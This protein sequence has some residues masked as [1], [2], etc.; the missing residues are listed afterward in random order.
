[1]NYIMDKVHILYLDDPSRREEIQFQGNTYEYPIEDYV[2]GTVIH[3]KLRDDDSVL[4]I[5]RKIS[6]AKNIAVERMYMYGVQKVQL[7]NEIVYQELNEMYKRPTFYHLREYLSNYREFENEDDHDDEYDYDDDNDETISFED[8]ITLNFKGTYH[9]YIAIGISPSL[10]VVNPFLIERLHS[11]LPNET[12]VENRQLLLDYNIEEL[13]VVI[14]EGEPSYSLERYYPNIHKESVVDKESFIKRQSVISYIENASENIETKSEGIQFI[15]FRLDQYIELPL[16]YIFNMFESSKSTPMIKYNPSNRLNNQYRIYSHS[17]SSNGDKIPYLNMKE[18]KRADE[19][20]ARSKGVGIFIFEKYDGPRIYCSFNPTNIEFAVFS[21]K[22]ITLKDVQHFIEKNLTP[23]LN[24]VFNYISDSGYPVNPLDYTKLVVVKSNLELRVPFRK[25]F[26]MN[27]V[28]KC[29]RQFMIVNQDDLV[30]KGIEMRYSRISNFKETDAITS[31]IIRIFNEYPLSQEM[32]LE[33]YAEILRENFDDM[34]LE[35]ALLKINEYIQ[36][37]AITD[38]KQRQVNPGYPVSMEKMKGRREIVVNVEGIDNYKYFEPMIKYFKGLIYLAQHSD[39]RDIQQICS[40]IEEEKVEEEDVSQDISEEKVEDKLKEDGVSELSDL[41]DDVSQDDSNDDSSSSFFGGNRQERTEEELNGMSLK[42]PNLFVQRIDEMEPGLILKRRTG[43]YNAYT[44]TCP[45]NVFRQPVILTDEEMKDISDNY[46]DAYSNAMEY[47]TN[48][49]EK[50]WYICPRYWCLKTGKPLTQEQV[51]SGQ[52][53]KVIPR[54]T[55]NVPK[56]HYVYEFYNPSEHGSRDSYRIHHPGLI[57]GKHP[58]GKCLPC[59]FKKWNYDKIQKQKEK[60]VGDKKESSSSPKE[61]KKI[62]LLYIKDPEKVPLD[63]SRIGYMSLPL[64]KMMRVDNQK[65]K[66]EKT[67]S[68]FVRIGNEQKKHNNFLSAFASLLTSSGKLSIDYQPQSRTFNL[69]SLVKKIIKHMTLDKFVKYMRGSL[70]GVFADDTLLDDEEIDELKSQTKY[71]YLPEFNRLSVAYT[72]FIEYIKG[73]HI[74][75]TY[76]WEL[77]SNG[78]IFGEAINIVLFEVLKPGDGS[79]RLEVVCPPNAYIKNYIFNDTRKT[80]FIVKQE[81]YYEAIV[82][83][84]DNKIQTAFTTESIP[85]ATLKT[86][87]FVEKL[88]RKCLPKNS[89][90]KTYT[91]D[92]YLTTTAVSRLVKR[93]AKIRKTVMNGLRIVGFEMKVDGVKGI[94][95]VEPYTSKEIPNKRISIHDVKIRYQQMKEFSERIT[96]KLMDTNLKY[97]VRSKVVEDG[98]VVGVMMN[99]NQMI[100]VIPETNVEDG[101]SLIHEHLFNDTDEV[102][103]EREKLIR[104]FENSTRQY[105]KIRRYIKK[106]LSTFKGL[107]VRR[108]IDAI[109]DNKDLV[110]Y[111]KIRN[112]S[113]LIRRINIGSK[114]NPRRIP[115]H[116]T[117]RLADELVRYGVIRNYVLDNKYNT[118]TVVPLKIGDSEIVY[119]GKELDTTFSKKSKDVMVNTHIQENAWIVAKPDKSKVYSKRSNLDFKDVPNKKIIIAKNKQIVEKTALMAPLELKNKRKLY[120]KLFG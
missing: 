106:Q 71:G 56:G 48:P 40:S 117:V 83:Y 66:Q 78:S 9:K 114:S 75:Y 73:T 59:C 120:D 55:S 29:V 85:R 19:F 79:E 14:L 51:D 99:T 103:V 80:V 60:C 46:R 108:V 100:P 47:S 118:F 98:M 84:K 81:E 91:F 31:K 92:D 30:G 44:R 57:S 22:V 13:K 119:I 111:D 35:E 76:V 15:K 41:Q 11:K 72:N 18:Y 110:L 8:I 116:Y 54:G 50:H 105:N 63:N 88:N 1:M 112:I 5:K 68:I 39:D 6:I 32:T 53:G 45:T 93:G 28:S 52:C 42:N 74:D 69:K 7:T 95:M 77:L 96:E 58:D 87:R 64:Q 16:N 113:K 94:V 24:K 34:S 65:H 17:I 61:V 82:N 43:K 12:I 36:V 2:Q 26:S 89:L 86:M 20:M 27:S 70:V 90:P 4:T 104:Q 109:I 25:S 10:P 102:D 67:T 107:K 49:D 38:K 115:I 23:V 33:K 21:K 62:K 37:Q 101:I 3:D 97:E